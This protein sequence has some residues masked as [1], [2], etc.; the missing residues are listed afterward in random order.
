[1]ARRGVQFLRHCFGCGVS[2]DGAVGRSGAQPATAGEGGH[3]GPE[4]F[5][6]LV[7]L[8]AAVFAARL[9]MGTAG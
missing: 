5:S 6:A 1:M 7:R 3:A 8:G 4:Q 2:Q 9:S